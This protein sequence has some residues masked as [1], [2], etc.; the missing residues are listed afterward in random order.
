MEIKLGYSS[1]ERI[2]S[3]E[4]VNKNISL[5]R[6]QVVFGPKFFCTYVDIIHKYFNVNS[7]KY[8]QDAKIYSYLVIY[9]VGNLKMIIYRS[10]H[11]L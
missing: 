4:K 8:D 11:C 6:E 3:F 2:S 7:R 10:Y 9:F 5:N 1:I